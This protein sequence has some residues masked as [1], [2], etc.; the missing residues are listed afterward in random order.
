MSEEKQTISWF[1]EQIE[2]D[3]PPAKPVIKP[4]LPSNPNPC[5]VKYGPGP[6]GETCE[7]CAHM[8]ILVLARDYYKCRLRHNTRGPKTDHKKQWDTC[9]KFKQRTQDIP[10]YDGRG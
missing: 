6:D 10:R 4:V 1:G 7:N 8:A 3:I 9:A 5:V 2:I